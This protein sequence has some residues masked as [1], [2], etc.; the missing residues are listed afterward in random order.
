MAPCSCGNA[1]PDWSEFEK[2][3]W[4]QLCKKDF[5]PEHPGVFDGPIPM[6][7]AHLLGVRF[8]RLNLETN[9]LEKLNFDTGE[10][11]LAGRWNPATETLEP[12]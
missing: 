10:Y 1:D 11:K 3:L 4:C 9:V 5:V 8:D 12:V 2:R 6:H 7:T